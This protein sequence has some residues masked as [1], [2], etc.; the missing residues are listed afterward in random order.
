MI[1]DFRKFELGLR[2]FATNE[3]PEAVGDLR[4]AVALEAHRGVVMM[5]PVDEGRLRGNWQVTVDHPAEGYGE[6]T[7]DESGGPTLAAGQAVI[8]SAKRSPFSLIWLHNGVPYAGYVNDGTAR[9]RAV[10]MVERTVER[11]QRMF[12]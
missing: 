10:H 3:V 11:I 4:D 7:I 9:S 6:D 1:D 12:K 2:D 8:A 5:T